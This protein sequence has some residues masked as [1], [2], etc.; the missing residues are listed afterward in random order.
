MNVSFCMVKEIIS[1]VSGL[2]VL[3]LTMNE[4]KRQRYHKIAGIWVNVV[5]NHQYLVCLMLTHV[6]WSFFIFSSNKQHN[7]N[8]Q[9]NQLAIVSVCLLGEFRE[10]K[11]R[12]CIV[13]DMSQCS[14]IST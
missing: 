11:R 14:A 2:M 5:F 4:Y 13:L 6:Q 12:H 10:K 7:W 9:K 3:D 8:K 1:L